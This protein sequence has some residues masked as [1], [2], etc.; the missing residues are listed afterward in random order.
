MQAGETG[1]SVSGHRGGPGYQM[2]VCLEPVLEK[3]SDIVPNGQSL[4]YGVHWGRLSASL[5]LKSFWQW[6]FDSTVTDVESI[7]TQTKKRWFVTC[8]S[9]PSRSVLLKN[10][11]AV[12]LR[13]KLVP[14]DICDRAVAVAVVVVVIAVMFCRALWFSSAEVPTFPLCSVF[15]THT[16]TDTHE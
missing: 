2:H 4:N 3:R 14:S 8:F 10:V 6:T 1:Y 15:H 5:R 11:F 7:L 16:A 13:S 12:I 9:F